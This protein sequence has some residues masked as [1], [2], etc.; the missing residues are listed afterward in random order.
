MFYFYNAFIN[1]KVSV[2]RPF[3]LLEHL[4]IA[5]QEIPQGDVLLDWKDQWKPVHKL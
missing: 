2:E 5:K 1:H 4:R 3:D